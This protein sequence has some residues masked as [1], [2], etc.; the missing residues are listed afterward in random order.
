MGQGSSIIKQPMNG[1]NLIEREDTKVDVPI[2]Y[3][4]MAMW[5]ISNTIN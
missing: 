4:D 1:K 2:L 5:G 3:V